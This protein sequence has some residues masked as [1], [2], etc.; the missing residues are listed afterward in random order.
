[1]CAMDIMELASA[2]KGGLDVRVKCGVCGEEL[3]VPRNTWL[4]KVAYVD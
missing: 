2:F 3:V 1:M 4:G